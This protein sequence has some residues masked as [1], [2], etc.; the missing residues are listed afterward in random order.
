[1]GRA[2]VCADPGAVPVL[3]SARRLRE[4]YRDA[5][6]RDRQLEDPRTLWRLSGFL[7]LA[8]TRLPGS[9]SFAN[10]R[11]CSRVR[12]IGNRL[13]SAAGQSGELGR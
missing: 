13:N 5:L 7:G 1:V 12:Q 9:C 6:R 8:D 2:D 11:W 3:G 10:R 4:E